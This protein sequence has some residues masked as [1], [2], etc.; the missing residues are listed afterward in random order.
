MAGGYPFSKF[1]GSGPLPGGAPEL[2]PLPPQHRAWVV[3]GGHGGSGGGVGIG[4]GG[5]GGVVTGFGVFSGSGGAGGGA[6]AGAGGFLYGGG[7]SDLAAFLDAS[8]RSDL[9]DLQRGFAACDDELAQI[10]AEVERVRLGINTKE[11]SQAFG[12]GSGKS[13]GT[14]KQVNVVVVG[15][16]ASEG[17]GTGSGKGKGKSK[18][19]TVVAGGDVV[20]PVEVKHTEDDAIDEHLRLEKER[21]ALRDRNLVQPEQPLPT[22]QHPPAPQPPPQPSHPVVPLQPPPT[23]QPPPQPS[24]PVPPAVEAPFQPQPQ[25]FHQPLVQPQ[26]VVTGGGLPVNL[27]LQLERNQEVLSYLAMG[28]LDGSG[29]HRSRG[30][31]RR[32]GSPRRGEELDEPERLAPPPRPPLPAVAWVVNVRDF[33]VP[34]S[35]AGGAAEDEGAAEEGGQGGDRGAQAKEQKRPWSSAATGLRRMEWSRLRAEKEQAKAAQAAAV[36]SAAKE[37]AAAAAPRPASPPGR[38]MRGGPPSP[39]PPRPEFGQD[40]RGLAWRKPALSPEEVRRQRGSFLPGSVSGG[41]VTTWT[42]RP[43]PARR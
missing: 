4:G 39:P 30:P 32:G 36:A 24:H 27:G 7:H 22:P 28:L 42:Q 25:H 2:R 21:L 18:Q 14:S 11:A 16:L 10:A 43:S 17:F 15:D 1:Q 23:P 6:A 9:A 37:Q 29:H 34:A 26:P 12:K 40:V 3:S 5:R 20:A 8:G 19:G 13:Q 33:A 31:R 38:A 41:V 35:P